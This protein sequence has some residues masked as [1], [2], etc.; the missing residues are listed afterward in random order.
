M[1]GIVKLSTMSLGVILAM[2]CLAPNLVAQDDNSDKHENRS[3]KQKQDGKSEESKELR[4]ETKDASASKPLSAYR[5]EFT[6]TEL[7][8]LKKI[9]SR[10]YSMLVQQGILNKLRIGVR[11]PVPTGVVPNSQFQYL[12]VGMSIDCT[13]QERDDLVLL[14][15]TMDV[16]GIAQREEQTHQ[17]AIRQ[18]KWEV[19]TILSPGKPTLVSSVDDPTSKG[20]FQLEVMATKVK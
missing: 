1:M 4:Q 10:S 6:V 12:D 13:I 8:D 2:G 11:V 14:S 19:R 18:T 9:N 3:D 20:R 16:S 15:S 17:P 5:L 7:D